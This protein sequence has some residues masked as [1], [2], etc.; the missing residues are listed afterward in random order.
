MESVAPTLTTSERRAAKRC[1]AKW[2]WAYREG[3][4]QPEMDVK[5]W[6][7][8]GIHECLAHMYGR[9]GTRRN[10][11]FVDLWQEYCDRDEY[12]KAV[13]TR[14][15]MDESV[16]TDA[17]SLGETMLL[18]YWDFYQGDPDWEVIAV[19]EPFQ[20]E[21]PDPDS[22]DRT[23][24]IF[25]STFD[26]VY[27]DRADGLVKLM[28]HKTADQ[29]N[30][31]FLQL[32]DQGGAYWAV[33]TTILRD[34]GVLG[35]RE[36]IAGIQ[37]NFLRKS[38]PDPRPRNAAGLY[39]NKPERKDYIEALTRRSLIAE[40]GRPPSLADMIA[41]ADAAGV[42]VHGEV[43][44]VQPKPLFEREFV[45]RTARERNTQIRRIADELLAL[46]RFRTG[47]LR[48]IKTPTRDCS[49]DCEFFQMCQ[50]HERGGPDWA[51]Y[52]DGVYVVEDP[53]SRYKLRKSAS[54]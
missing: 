54:S 38:R 36:S 14:N 39:L 32:D 9:L 51:E 33:A 28:E 49:W 37:Y 22:P 46:E 40:G 10:K 18:E 53:Y 31:A 45:R 12:S 6:F 29:I 26:G 42:T 19:E 20:I 7:G 24:G 13:R 43:S 1:I 35:P 25:T 30:L 41:I 17:R 21:I 2:W 48:I 52:R 47:E 11:D 5:L 16:W 8:I 50:L 3:L 15:E 34:K 4:R 44:K 23:V 27:R